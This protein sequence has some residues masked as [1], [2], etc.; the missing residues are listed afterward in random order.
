[1]PKIEVSK[2][3]LITDSVGLKEKF[4]GAGEVLSVG[5][6][7]YIPLNILSICFIVW[8]KASDMRLGVRQR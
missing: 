5:N 3:D 4:G 8:T 1:M 6:L 7:W 2:T